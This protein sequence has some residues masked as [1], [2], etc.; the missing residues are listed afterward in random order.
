MIGCVIALENE[1]EALL[2]QMQIES[3]Q[4][5]YG[6]PVYLGTAFG[7]KILLT[8][9]G[10]GKVNAAVGCTLLLERG[11]DAIFNFGVAGGLHSGTQ[12]AEV[13]SI[14]KAVQYDFDIT[15]IEGGEIGTLDG[16]TENFLPVRVIGGLNLP[17]RALGSGDRFNDS[18][19]DHELLLRLGA[20]IRDMEGAAIAQVCKC[21]NVPFFSV[22]AISDVYGAGSTTEQYTKNLARASLALKE[23]VKEAVLMIAKDM[24]HD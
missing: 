10:V 1:A 4:T 20:D 24:R 21:A 11:A 9:C 2:S 7:E 22:K 5:V 13:Y 15:Q 16:E 17:V 3:R 19:A 18:P 14:E 6:K 23:H 8:V 12:I